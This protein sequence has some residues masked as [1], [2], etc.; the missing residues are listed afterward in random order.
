MTQLAG[1]G[2]AGGAQT[3][4]VANYLAT[5]APSEERV[6]GLRPLEPEVEEYYKNLVRKHLSK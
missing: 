1:L 4:S 6:P 2:A 3:V 5:L